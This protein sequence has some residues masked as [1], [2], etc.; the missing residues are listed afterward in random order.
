MAHSMEQYR[1]AK[2]VESNEIIRKIYSNFLSILSIKDFTKLFESES[3]ADVSKTPEMLR[4]RIVQDNVAP[5]PFEVEEHT[6]L[7][8]EAEN[9]DGFVEL[10]FGLGR[11]LNVHVQKIYTG[12]DARLNAKNLSIQNAS[13]LINKLVPSGK[14]ELDRDDYVNLG[15]DTYVYETNNLKVYFRYNP[16]DTPSLLPGESFSFMMTDTSPF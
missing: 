6:F 3:L 13:A 5:M 14:I 7:F 8:W 2:A 16:N 12:N 4:K 9:C 15:V 11:L 1:P 10:G